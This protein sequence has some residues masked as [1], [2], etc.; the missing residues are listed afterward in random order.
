MHLPLVHQAPLALVHK[1]DRV[2]DTQNIVLPVVIKEITHRGKRGWL[3]RPSWTRYQQQI[4][5]QHRDVSEYL[6]HAQ[7]I[8]QHSFGGNR[9][10]DSTSPPDTG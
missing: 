9:P 6:A 7:R 4:S 3:A 8:H 1:L 5:G 10:E 2:L